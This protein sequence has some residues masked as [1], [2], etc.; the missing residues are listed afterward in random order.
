MEEVTMELGL[1][2]YTGMGC[3][4]AA[5]LGGGEGG[6]ALEWGKVSG[7]PEG[8]VAAEADR[9]TECGEAFGDLLSLGN[10]S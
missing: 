10:C 8:R 7:G 2:G 5:Q 6:V 9:A 1:E 4:L 3:V